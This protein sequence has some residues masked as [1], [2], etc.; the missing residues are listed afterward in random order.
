[1]SITKTISFILNHPFN[2]DNKVSALARFVKWQINGMLNPYPI[3]YPFTENSTLIVKKGMAGATGNLYCGL[4]E[5]ED[6]A[7]LLHLLRET[8]LFVDVGANIGSFTILA[9]GEICANS[10]SFEPIP[11]T[12]NRL[13]DNVNINRLGH[14]V[15]AYNIGI[16]KEKGKIKFT[17][18]FDTVNHVAFDDSG[19]QI[20]VEVNTLDNL[21]SNAP[22]LIKI[23][24]E[25]FETEVIMGAD[26]LLSNTALKAIIIELNGSG[27][28]YGFKD[29]DIHKKILSYGF[30]T[31]AYN[32]ATRSLSELESFG[33]FNTLYLRDIPFINKRITTARK[34]R[35]GKQ[36]I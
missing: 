27:S 19:N 6:M 5:Y 34:V 16:G 35:I 18:S 7:F 25:G 32:P 31:F 3:L 33:K 11:A 14:K 36:D 15:Q 4:V 17:A 20:E 29:E 10:I 24:V 2:K 30:K 22:T 9:S 13:L 12:Y 23:D 28:N 26:K 21:L 8:D 1:M